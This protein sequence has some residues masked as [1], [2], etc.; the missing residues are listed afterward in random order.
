MAAL[1]RRGLHCH[2]CTGKLKVVK[3]SLASAVISAPGVWKFAHVSILMMMMIIVM[4]VMKTKEA[5]L[6]ALLQKNANF[7]KSRKREKNIFPVL[8]LFGPSC[9][10]ASGETA[11]SLWNTSRT[12]DLS[13]QGPR[14]IVAHS[15]TGSLC[16][17]YFFFL[18]LWLLGGCRSFGVDRILLCPT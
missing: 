13:V 12:L 4:V 16:Q 5:S 1:L 10:W 15:L 8:V 18:F 9:L 3:F 2:S 11:A 17:P 7:W 14:R 6:H